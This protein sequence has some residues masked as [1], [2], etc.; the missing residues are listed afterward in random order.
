[1][2]INGKLCMMELDIVVDFLIMSRSEYLERFVDKFLFFF[3]VIFKIYMGELF[4]VLGEMQCDIVYKGKLYFLF[5]FVVNYDV[6]FILFGKNWL[7][8]IKF[9]WGE[10]FCIFKGDFR[11]VDS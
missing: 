1:M 11:S 10:I 9:E 8:Y 4:D 7:W 3:K 6:K 2:E 5:I